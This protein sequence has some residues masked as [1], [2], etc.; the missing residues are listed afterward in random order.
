[1]GKSKVLLI[2]L[3]GVVL[4]IGSTAT[5]IAQESGSVAKS[6]FTTEI[7]NREPVNDLDSVSTDIKQ[8]YFFTEIRNMSGN[9]ITHRWLH[10][11]ETRAEISFNVGGPRW[12]VHSSKNLIPEWVGDWT[13]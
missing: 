10:G 9:R 8:I 5:A 12:R 7:V 2:A 1:M 11:G 3:L 13:V 4:V 6:A